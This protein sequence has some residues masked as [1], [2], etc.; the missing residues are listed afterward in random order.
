MGIIS[1]EISKE[2][3]FKHF[4][5]KLTSYLINSSLY[6]FDDCNV[7][8]YNLLCV[9]YTGT[10]QCIFMNKE[11]FNSIQLT[12]RESGVMNRQLCLT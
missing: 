10:I 2:N 5:V 3:D 9:C 6:N 7:R 8:V 11:I 1:T 12:H 4:K